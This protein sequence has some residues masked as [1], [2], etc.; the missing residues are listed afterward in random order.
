[1]GSSA[2]LLS[3]GNVLGFPSPSTMS[4]VVLLTRS[5]SSSDVL[6]F[7]FMILGGGVDR[8]G[9]KTCDPVIFLLLPFNMLIYHGMV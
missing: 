5:S 9:M 8:I 6:I 7:I 4:A 1:M 3:L 2:L